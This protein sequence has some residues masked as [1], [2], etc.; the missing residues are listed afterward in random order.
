MDKWLIPINL[1]QASGT[2]PLTVAFV[3]CDFVLLFII[4]ASPPRNLNQSG[5][6]E[7][8]RRCGAPQTSVEKVH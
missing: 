1:C 6:W 4:Y 2:H 7:S 5:K 8:G 3:L